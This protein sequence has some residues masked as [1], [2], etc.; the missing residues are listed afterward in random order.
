LRHNPSISSE[1]FR[2]VLVG[3]E[4]RIWKTNQKGYSFSQVALST[5]LRTDIYPLG[6]SALMIAVTIKLNIGH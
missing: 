2:V 3:A 4:I 6:Y 5:I 1:A